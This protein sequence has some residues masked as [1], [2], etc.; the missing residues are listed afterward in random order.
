M[1]IRFSR[2][3]LLLALASV[4]QGMSQAAA[5]AFVTLQ[6]A[7][8]RA[9]TAFVPYDIEYELTF[10]VDTANVKDEQKRTL[11]V[12]HQESKD[13]L[14]AQ[15][16]QPTKVFVSEQTV[17]MQRNNQWGCTT[18]PAEQFAA[19]LQRKSMNLYPATA[20]RLLKTFLDQSAGQVMVA[21][22]GSDIIANRLCNAFRVIVDNT[23]FDAKSA[24][25]L[26][27]VNL[28]PDVAASSTAGVTLNVCFDQQ[29]GQLLQ[30]TNDIVME[31]PMAPGTI[32]GELAATA[33]RTEPPSDPQF[34]AIPQQ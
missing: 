31:Q 20:A 1:K 9:T 10:A 34:Y 24:A 18:V 23:R 12:I 27:Y 30:Y 11:R 2:S 32:R 8:E 25:D 7:L 14:F 16:E 5:P 22:G 26:L 33:F 21:S 19:N 29:T 15:T 6:Q 13:Y 4:S 28:P 3:V 17:C